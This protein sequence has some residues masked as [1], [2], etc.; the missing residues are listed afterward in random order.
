MKANKPE[1]DKL[2][3]TVINPLD[4]LVASGTITQEQETSIESAFEAAM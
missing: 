3:T 4:S 1:P 2:K